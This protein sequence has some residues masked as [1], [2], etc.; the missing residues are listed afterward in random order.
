M[1]KIIPFIVFVLV[2]TACGMDGKPSASKQAVLSESEWAGNGFNDASLYRAGSENKKEDGKDSRDI[3]EERKLVRNGSLTIQ[4]SDLKSI[5]STINVLV[6]NYG[7]YISSSTDYSNESNYV[8]RIPSDRFDE[9]MNSLDKVGKIL[10]RSVSA[11]D[12]TDQFYDLQTRLETKKILRDKYNQ[13]LLKAQNVKDMLEIERQLNDVIYDI[14]SIEGSLKLLNN[15][16]DYSTITIT[17]RTPEKTYSPDY[18]INGISV[19]EVFYDAGNFLVSVFSFL[20]YFI[21]YGV[22]ILAVV[23]LLYWLLLG[24]IGLLKKFF[25]KLRGKVENKAKK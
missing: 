3:A 1:K 4:V 10:S 13:Y 20:I 19:K 22:P 11:K 8:I 16:I 5:S 2:F 25:I 12:V 6:E 17:F 15:Q 21:I 7:G 18:T 23:A 9:V 24:K 14:E